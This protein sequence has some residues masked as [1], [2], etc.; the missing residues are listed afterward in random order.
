M[1]GWVPVCL[2]FSNRMALTGWLDVFRLIDGTAVT[3]SD[4]HMWLVPF[5]EG[6]NHTVT[7][8]FPQETL[9][10]GLRLWNYN[11][12]P[13]D[14]YRGV[15]IIKLIVHITSRIIDLIVQV[16]SAQVAIWGKPMFTRSC[17]LEV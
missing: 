10:S 9:V 15:R 2:V 6:Q 4:E 13:E 14:T 7:I 1:V 16:T 12:S 17:L 5:T 3:M 8:T 11:K